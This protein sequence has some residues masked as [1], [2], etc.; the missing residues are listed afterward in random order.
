MGLELDTQSLLNSLRAERQALWQDTA[1]TPPNGGVQLALEH[2]TKEI[3]GGNT[4]GFR[5]LLQGCLETDNPKGA[6][7]ALIDRLMPPK[8][9]CTANSVDTDAGYVG[10]YRTPP[11]ET[12]EVSNALQLTPRDTL[13][14]IGGGNGTTAAIFAL[15]NPKA[16]IVSLELQEDLNQQ[17]AALKARFNLNNLTVIQGDALR[18]DLSSASAL[19]LYFP[20]DDRHFSRLLERFD[21]EKVPDFVLRGN[22]SEIL[23]KKF[24]SLRDSGVTFFSE[25]LSWWQGSIRNRQQ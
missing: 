24:D 17:A 16:T 20:F 22:N 7:G 21:P 4:D 15:L 12:L 11:L 9:S 14:D 3:Q 10:Y 25:E 18:V 5:A 8:P 1:L 19:Y 2:L 13:F 23:T 6:A